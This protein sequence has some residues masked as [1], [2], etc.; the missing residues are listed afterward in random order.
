M[1]GIYLEILRSPSH[2]PCI[3]FQYCKNIHAIITA[4]NWHN[5]T[6]EHPFHMHYPSNEEILFSVWLPFTNFKNI[7]TTIWIKISTFPMWNVIQSRLIWCE[8]LKSL[9]NKISH[10]YWMNLIL[11]VSSECQC[12]H[13]MNHDRNIADTFHFRRQ[14]YLLSLQLLEDRTLFHPK[15]GGGRIH[16]M[17]FGGESEL[18]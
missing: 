14:V 7:S 2:H 4:G 8:K 3:A 12:F 15:L 11:D 16:C 18:N 13:Y 17:G 1:S 5:Y 6:T 9:T 10:T